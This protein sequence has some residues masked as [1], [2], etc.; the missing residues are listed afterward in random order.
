MEQ[1]Q[2]RMQQMESLMES[3]NSEQRGQL[4]D[5]MQSMM[6]EMGLEGELSELASHLGQ[7]FPQER[8]QSYP[9]RGDDP[10]TMQEA[11]RMMEE[12]AKLEE[13]ESSLKGVRG[14]DEIPDADV[15]QLRELLATMP[16][17][18]W[19]TCESWRASWKKPATCSVR[20]TAWN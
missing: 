2:N 9:F 17:N 15:E 4:Q 19:R 10:L 13:M 6:G 8:A 3:L 11:M 5:M 7:M 12:M 1:L 14:P 18:S 16:H 20:A